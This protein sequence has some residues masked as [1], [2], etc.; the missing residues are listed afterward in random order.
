M[1]VCKSMYK[2]PSGFYVG[3]SEGETSEEA[4][5][6][7]MSSCKL[8]GGQMIYLSTHE[9]CDERAEEGRE[10]PPAPGE[11]VLG[12]E[13]VP[14]G[15]QNEGAGDHHG[16][17]VGVHN[18][19]DARRDLDLSWVED[20]L[21]VFVAERNQVKLHKLGKHRLLVN[22]LLDVLLLEPPLDVSK[23]ARVLANLPEVRGEVRRD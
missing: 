3:T 9:E 14:S 17:F 23:L 11:D 7:A 5:G 13:V 22:G 6:E 15:E 4:E 19:H 21:L 18:R 1:F 10:E 8:V 16:G 12:P 2:T 20:D